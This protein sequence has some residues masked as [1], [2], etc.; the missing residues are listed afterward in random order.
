MSMAWVLERFSFGEA[1][2]TVGFAN[3]NERIKGVHYN[4]IINWV[5]QVGKLL[6]NAYAPLGG[7]P[8]P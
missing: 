1:V 5:K 6:P 8:H 2:P 3:A 4:S 7:R